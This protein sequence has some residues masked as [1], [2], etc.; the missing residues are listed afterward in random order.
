MLRRSEEAVPLP[1]AESL[2]LRE[3]CS[4]DG[5]GLEKGRF[6]IV[7]WFWTLWWTETHWEQ[8]KVSG[9]REKKR[10]KSFAA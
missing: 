6:L 3:G 10:G 4:Q 1:A 2:K 9:A 8:M 7:F 5:G